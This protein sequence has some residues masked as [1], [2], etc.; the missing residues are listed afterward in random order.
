MKASENTAA[1]PARQQ[2]K[3]N[4]SNGTFLVIAHAATLAAPF[5][6]S[7]RALITAA[8]LYWVAGS[9]GIGMGFHRLLAH[10]GYKVPK[11]VEYF[12]VTCGT[13]AIEGGPIQWRSEEHTSELQS[14]HD[15]VCRLLL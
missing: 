10:R 5:F 1:I 9:L 13:L 6:W 11:L 7:W 2:L 8:V 4:W 12:L 3:I 14:H 15:L